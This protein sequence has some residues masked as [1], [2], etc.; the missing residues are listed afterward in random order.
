MPSHVYGQG[1]I[2]G[3]RLHDGIAWRQVVKGWTHDGAGWRLITDLGALP[4]LTSV[5]AEA[6]DHDNEARARVVTGQHTQSVA[7]YWRRNGGAWTAM[8]AINTA[9]VGGTYYTP[10][11]SVANDDL[12]EFQFV[13]WSQ[14]N[15]G[16][17][18][19]DV[20]TDGVTLEPR[21]DFTDWDLDRSDANNTVWLNFTV[22]GGTRSVRVEYEINGGVRQALEEFDVT[23]G[24]SYQTADVQA[25]EGDTVEVFV[26]AFSADNQGGEAGDTISPQTT[27]ADETPS[28]GTVTEDPDT[29]DRELRLLFKAG[30]NCHQVRVR[31]RRWTAG[32]PVPGYTTDEYINTVPGSATQYATAWI[33]ALGT[34]DEE[35]YVEIELTP[36]NQHGDAG[37]D[38]EGQHYF[39]PEVNPT[40]TVVSQEVVSNRLRVTFSAN[41]D[42]GSVKVEY[43]V[44][45]TTNYTFHEYMDTNHSTV[46]F[47][48]DLL[49][50][51]AQPEG[52]V[53]RIRLTPYSGLA[54]SGEV[55]GST[56]A[57]ET[58][59]PPPQTYF[60][61]IESHFI[62]TSGNAAFST[63]TV[64]P[65]TSSVL[66]YADTGSG[67]TLRQEILIDTDRTYQTDLFAR[68]TAGQ[69]C[70]R[71]RPLSPD[72]DVGPDDEKCATVSGGV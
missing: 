66:V 6:D 18:Q 56:Q 61:L 69:V 11:L 64:N 53:V 49:P 17:V 37:A 43:S 22:N 19:G 54:G 27:L 35:R 2:V 50:P 15:L 72:N 38:F 39:P 42:A 48:T 62:G 9:T 23:P 30:A 21:P 36:Y 63:F 12:V 68:P 4:L 33:P 41:D 26:Q 60:P 67:F 16:G 46:N 70:I 47:T 58:M 51:T 5:V 57:T 14:P 65:D 40:V 29:T 59:P 52:A 34:I 7:P 28:L 44:N 25:G 31:F 32:D 71:L 45:S 10:W 55:G 24:G 13:A 20:K 3:A 8:A 1:N